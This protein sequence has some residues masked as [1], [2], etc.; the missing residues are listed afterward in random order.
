MVRSLQLLGLRV[1]Q[2]GSLHRTTVEKISGSTRVALG[3]ECTL[4]G[5]YAG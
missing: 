2:V 5:Y 3:L 1:Y 4:M